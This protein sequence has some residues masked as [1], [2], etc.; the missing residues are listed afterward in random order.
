M[1]TKR[2][3]SLPLLVILM[4]MVTACTDDNNDNNPADARA[5]YLGNWLVNE[6]WTKLTYEVTITEDS[7][8]TDGVYISNFG[9]GG[10]PAFAFISGT[11]ISLT[12]DEYL[13]NGWI[14]NGSGGL[15]GSKITWSYTRND[16][17]NLIYASA[18]YT[19]N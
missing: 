3:I 11:T 19:K 14:V 1:K 13:S 18:T 15:S 4:C 17:A 5:A 12:T 8:S 10:V 16:G 9:G 6:Q 7:K 2:F